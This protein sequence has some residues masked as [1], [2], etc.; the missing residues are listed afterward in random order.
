MLV[1]A[2]LPSI[3]CI[4]GQAAISAT[5]RVQSRRWLRRIVLSVTPFSPYLSFEAKL[6]CLYF[7]NVFLIFFFLSPAIATIYSFS[8]GD[9]LLSALPC[10][11]LYFYTESIYSILNYCGWYI[12]FMPSLLSALPPTPRLVINVLKIAP[13]LLSFQLQCLAYSVSS[14]F[15]TV[16]KKKKKR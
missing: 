15:V 12:L 16:N 11:H 1:F 4:S 9:I 10:L 8:L 3:I 2:S 6:K 13:V 14:L 7:K 5:K